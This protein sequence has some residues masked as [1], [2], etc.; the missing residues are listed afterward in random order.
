M[1]STV[2][3]FDIVLY[4]CFGLLDGSWA[5]ISNSTSM[6]IFVHQWISSKKNRSY[7]PNRICRNH[8]HH[9][10][11]SL[12][13][14]SRILW[15][16]RFLYNPVH[17][18]AFGNSGLEPCQLGQVHNVCIFHN[19]PSISSH[20]RNSFRKPPLYIM[21]CWIQSH[22]NCLWRVSRRMGWNESKSHLHSSKFLQSL[23][24]VGGW[25]SIYHLQLLVQVIDSCS[26]KSLTFW[27]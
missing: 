2:S 22:H 10:C 27:T 16:L 21:L 12:R 9:S 1:S 24:L 7:W 3:I 15:W 20:L 14:T 13:S 17:V 25:Y 4:K 23:M 5:T 11:H 19:I 8:T 18:R 26:C 6:Y